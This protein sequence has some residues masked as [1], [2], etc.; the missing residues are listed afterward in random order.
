[1]KVITSMK[2]K[3][4]IAASVL[5]GA[6]GMAATGFG[7]AVASADPPPPP[8]PGQPGP[9]PPGMGGPGDHSGSHRLDQVG[10]GDRLG[11]RRPAAA[12][13]GF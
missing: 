8:G 4:V 12:T 9:P 11:R 10:Q 1:M 3:K 6:L 13:A 2:V 7:V 5:A